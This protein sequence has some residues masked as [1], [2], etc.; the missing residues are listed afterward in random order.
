[1]MPY[2]GTGRQSGVPDLTCRR[3]ETIRASEN[4]DRGDDSSEILPPREICVKKLS[5]Q[6]L[7]QQFP[8]RLMLGIRPYSSRRRW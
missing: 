7:S 1:M 8:L 3:G 6:A 5:T 2:Y 4:L